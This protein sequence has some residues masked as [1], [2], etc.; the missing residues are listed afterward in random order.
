MLVGGCG[1]GESSSNADL[2]R[3]FAIPIGCT[4]ENADPACIAECW[5]GDG[6]VPGASN[7]PCQSDPLCD[8]GRWSF[9]CL[10]LP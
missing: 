10:P 2:G 3:D 1:R 4:L 9:V 6:G 5:K 8:N 7:W